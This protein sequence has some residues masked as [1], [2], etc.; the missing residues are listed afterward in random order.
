MEELRC[1]QLANGF[2]FC[3]EWHTGHNVE[4]CNHY[5]KMLYKLLCLL[6]YNCLLLPKKHIST[7]LHDAH[8]FGEIYTC[9]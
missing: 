5:R 9:C 2:T 3:C 4:L 1:D 8:N 6:M 7:S